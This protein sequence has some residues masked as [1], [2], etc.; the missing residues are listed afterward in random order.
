M[1]NLATLIGSLY[2]LYIAVGLSSWI[3]GGLV[4][5]YLATR[6]APAPAPAPAP[7]RPA[8]LEPNFWANEDAGQ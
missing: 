3:M 8:R 5:L 2:L 7:A 4:D 1:H 6:Q